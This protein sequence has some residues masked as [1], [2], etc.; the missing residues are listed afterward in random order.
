MS[1]WLKLA[2]YCFIRLISKQNVLSMNKSNLKSSISNYITLVNQ[3]L[4]LNL[5]NHIILLTMYI[6]IL[7][8]SWSKIGKSFKIWILKPWKC[9]SLLVRHS[10]VSILSKNQS[11][12]SLLFFLAW[13]SSVRSNKVY[14]KI[15]NYKLPKLISRLKLCFLKM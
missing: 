3:E 6:K 11:R 13:W 5:K 7:K 14:Q 1:N 2:K 9:R 12:I 10:I 8:S 4:V 15:N